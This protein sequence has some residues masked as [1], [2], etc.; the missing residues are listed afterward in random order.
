MEIAEMWA[1]KSHWWL[2]TKEETIATLDAPE[3]VGT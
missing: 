3:T 1:V 2:A